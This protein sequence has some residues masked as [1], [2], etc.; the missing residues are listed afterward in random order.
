MADMDLAL[1][2]GAKGDKGD[3]GPRGPQGIQGPTGPQGPAG[4]GVIENSV[5]GYDVS[6]SDALADSQFLSFDIAGAASQ[7]YYNGVQLLNVSTLTPGTSGNATV[8]FDGTYYTLVNPDS[9]VR[10]PCISLRSTIPAG[11]RYCIYAIGGTSGVGV[12]IRSSGTDVLYIEDVGSRQSDAA[13]VSV[14]LDEICFGIPAGVRTTIKVIVAKGSSIS[15]W[16]PYT[17]G[18]PSPNEN[19]PQEIKVATSPVVQVHGTYSGTSQTFSTTAISLP[20]SHAYA[21]ALSNGVADMVKV[22]DRGKVTVQA[23]V[24]RYTSAD[25]RQYELRA[26]GVDFQVQLGPYAV[27]AVSG[28]YG[29]LFNIA[30]PGD[31]YQTSAVS[32]AI[33]SGAFLRMTRPSSVTDLASAKTYLAS[34]NLVAYVEL[35]SDRYASYTTSKVSDLTM[36][37]TPSSDYTPFYIKTYDGVLNTQ[38]SNTTRYFVEG[39]REVSSILDRLVAL[40]S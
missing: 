18:I 30:I 34:L 29:A 32:G 21:V 35:P 11:A 40:E 7:T 33:F 4:A 1:V 3:Q 13:N 10:Y 24:C 22:S 19:Y 12:Y 27:S 17:G 36:P 37:R 8:T 5:T 25:A 23:K 15:T 9:V 38:L 6:I 28:S 2:V 26:N 20:S 31:I 14:N 16:E 39:G